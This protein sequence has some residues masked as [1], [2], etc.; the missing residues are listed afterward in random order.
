MDVRLKKKDSE[1]EKEGNEEEK[2]SRDLLDSRDLRCF[3]CGDAGHQTD[4]L[5]VAVESVVPT[6]QEEMYR[7]N[8][9]PQ[10]PANPAVVF[11]PQRQ[12]HSAE[13]VTFKE[14]KTNQVLI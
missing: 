8:A 4:V 12:L 5:P 3:I 10:Q 7:S 14:S 2:D 9:S 6:H 11:V 1:E 13:K